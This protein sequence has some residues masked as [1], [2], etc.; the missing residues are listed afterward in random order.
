MTLA[1]IAA[2]TGGSVLGD[3]ALVVTA[4]GP[5]VVSHAIVQAGGRGI[6]QSLAAPFPE[7]V[8]VLPGG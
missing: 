5:V 7:T 3:P 2:V 8:V 4:D 6:A 1:E